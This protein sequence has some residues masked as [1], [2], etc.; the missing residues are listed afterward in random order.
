M[1]AHDFRSPLI[2][3]LGILD[4]LKDDNVD[5][6]T[7]ARFYISAERDVQNI[8]LIFDNILQWV[9]KQITGYE[10]VL[11]KINIFDL[12]VQSSS[13]FLQAMQDKKIIFNNL[14]DPQ[15]VVLSDKEI[16]QFVNR[17]LLH[18]AIKHSRE[19]GI[20]TV[21]QEMK[22]NQL[23]ICVKNE[24]DG[25]SEK[26]LADLFNFKRQNSNDG[27]AGMA[28]TLALEFIMLLGGRIWAESTPGKDAK[29]YYVLSDKIISEPVRADALK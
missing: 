23:N 24:G 12:I 28:L 20:I 21:S 6:E 18:N 13:M 7:R 10:P 26:Q 14:I 8:L 29:F 4:L 22:G 1:M 5:K 15:Q 27:G 25:M 2:Q 11:E 16:L 3:V 9:K 19:H 17:N